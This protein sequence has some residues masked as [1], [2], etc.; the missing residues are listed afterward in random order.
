M[1]KK[2][3]PAILEKFLPFYLDKRNKKGILLQ[4]DGAKS[5]IAPNDPDWRATVE[6]TGKHI[7]I[8]NQ[9]AN[10]WIQTSMVFLSSVQ[11]SYCTMM[12]LPW[13]N[14]S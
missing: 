13:V 8:Y 1:V 4:Q 10:L 14:G 2:V 6:A 11:F 3:L 9:P 7:E 5:H 12:N